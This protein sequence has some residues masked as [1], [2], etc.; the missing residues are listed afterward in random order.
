MRTVV[1]ARSAKSHSYAVAVFDV[2]FTR[3]AHA[4]YDERGSGLRSRSV[5]S[6]T[7]DSGRYFK[8]SSE[9]SHR[10]GI[11]RNVRDGNASARR[12]HL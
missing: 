7:D 6:Q 10:Y 9:T 4:V 1:L 12:Y 2:V 8:T 3:V 5:F 11:F